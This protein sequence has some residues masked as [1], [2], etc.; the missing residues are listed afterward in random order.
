M[1]VQK[2][3]SVVCA[4]E[5]RRGVFQNNDLVHQLPEITFPRSLQNYG[6]SFLLI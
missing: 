1:L 5:A 6:W 3:L 4:W 2:Q